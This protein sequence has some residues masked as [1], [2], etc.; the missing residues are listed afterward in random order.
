MSKRRRFDHTGL[1]VD[2]LMKVK[3]CFDEINKVASFVG[4]ST[5]KQKTCLR[6]KYG[7][8]TIDSVLESYRE[9]PG[10]IPVTERKTEFLQNISESVAALD[11]DA[12]F[13]QLVRLDIPPYKDP[14]RHSILAPPLGYCQFGCVN[15]DTGDPYMLSKHNQAI[16]IRYVDVGGVSDKRKITLRCAKCRRNYNLTQHGFKG[17]FQMYE[18]KQP[19]IE[20]TDGVVFSRRVFDHY[21]SLHLHC[22]TTFE[23]FADSY[24]EAFAGGD[25]KQGID[26]KLVSSLYFNGEVEEELRRLGK[27]NFKFKSNSLEEAF[28]FINKERQK[29]IYAHEC[30]AYCE[31]KGCRYLHVVDG[32]WKITFNVCSMRTTNSVSS[33]P[34]IKL[35]DTC[36][37]QPASGSAFC[38]EHK[39]EME[40]LNI[41]TTPKEFLQHCGVKVKEIKKKD[42]TDDSVYEPSETDEQLSKKVSDT[43]KKHPS[44]L[45]VG[46]SVISNQ[47]ARRMLDDQAQAVTSIMRDCEVEGHGSD[48]PAPCNK[49]T[50][51]KEGLHAKSRGYLFAVSAGGFIETFSPIYRSESPSQAFLF[52]LTFLYTLLQ[53]VP[54]EEWSK[55][56]LAY[57]NMCN[58]TRLR[59]S[60][61]PTLPLPGNFG[62]MWASINK[63]ID[64][65]HISNHKNKSCHQ[66]LHPRLFREKHKDLDKTNSMAAEQT[67]SWLSRYNKQVCSLPKQQQVFVLHRLSIRRNEYTSRCHQQ[68]KDPKAH[69]KIRYDWDD[70]TSSS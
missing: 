66:N 5:D 64:G 37:N 40:K 42:T 1:S 61:M 50:G 65:L 60:K 47:G 29:A 68:Q 49:D 3:E 43:M 46:Q 8:D 14:A 20:A 67:F 23:G 63:I 30:T 39:K 69:K 17:A 12:I 33:L 4:F 51:G 36:T 6:I 44:I 26:R 38:T 24:T 48:T 9:I 56:F 28:E 25:E 57:D 18:E 15:S 52:M 21:C 27:A 22:W 55:F 53:D 62:K 32:I 41:P 10:S 35:P 7:S 19:I 34:L 2:A 31:A 13:D 54:F 58:I 11:G 70:Q 45:E 16:A 59:A